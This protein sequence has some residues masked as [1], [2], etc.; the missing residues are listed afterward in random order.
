MQSVE[1]KKKVEM[2]ES[3][4]SEVG[5]GVGAAMDGWPGPHLHKADWIVQT[6]KSGTGEESVISSAAS[7]FIASLKE[8]RMEQIS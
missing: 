8:Q 7:F 1:Q 2:D 5:W 4:E 6:L 3:S